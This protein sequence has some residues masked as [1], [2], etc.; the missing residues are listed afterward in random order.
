MLVV[1]IAGAILGAASWRTPEFLL[2]IV[3]ILSTLA[4]L[5]SFGNWVW[6]L[7][8]G[9]ILLAQ[10]DAGLAQKGYAVAAPAVYNQP[11]N[12]VNNMNNANNI[13][14]VN[15]GD[16]QMNNQINQNSQ[17]NGEQASGSTSD[18]NQ[19]SENKAE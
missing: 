16:N 3:G 15:N 7:V 2:A 17:K 10:G 1:L 12:N 5:V 11:M 8:E 13:N 4:G 18:A 9:I 14:N 6:G 19:A